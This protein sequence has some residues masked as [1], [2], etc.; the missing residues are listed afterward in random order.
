MLL[1]SEDDCEAIGGTWHP[2]WNLCEP[3][4]CETTPPNDATW[5]RIKALYR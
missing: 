5:G 3:N 1:Y 2:D 4:P